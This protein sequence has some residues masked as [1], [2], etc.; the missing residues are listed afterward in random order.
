MP[1]KTETSRVLRVIQKHPEGLKL[2]ELGN[3][4]GVN[5]RTLIGAVGSLV[6]EGKIG[7]VDNIYYP[8]IGRSRADK[9]MDYE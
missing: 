9:E 5:W 8:I 1:V 6:D 4:L 7:K 3:A 2:V